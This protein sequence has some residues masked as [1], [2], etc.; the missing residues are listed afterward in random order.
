MVREAKERANSHM[1]RSSPGIF[2]AI[3][4]HVGDSPESIDPP[5][6]EEGTKGRL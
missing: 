5:E 1:K 3:Q 2:E 4:I 6:H